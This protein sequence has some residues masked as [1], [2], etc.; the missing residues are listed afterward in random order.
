MSKIEAHHLAEASLSNQHIVCNQ[1]Q[2]LLQSHSINRTSRV[3]T[4]SMKM[5]QIV[6]QQKD[7]E[8]GQKPQRGTWFLHLLPH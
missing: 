1:N 8:F 2:D 4:I 3:V 6:K 5:I 7:T